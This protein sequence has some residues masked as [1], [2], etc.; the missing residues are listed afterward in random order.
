[1]PFNIVIGRS[2]DDTEKYGTDG[3]VFIGKQYVHMGQVTSLSNN[4]YLDVSRSHVV[5][6]AG[7]RG[8]G[9]CLHEDSI[10]TLG[11]GSHISIKDLFMNARKNGVQVIKEEDEESFSV[12]DHFVI[13]LCGGVVSKRLVSHV[14]RKKIAENLLT[15]KTKKKKIT[16]TK[17]HQ[18]LVSEESN[19]LLLWKRSD[20]L[21]VGNII[22]VSDGKRIEHERI[23]SVESSFYE[24]WVYDITVPETHNFIGNG[25][26]CHNSYSMG[27]IAEGITTLPKDVRQNLSIILLDTMGVYWTMKYPNHQDSSL[28]KEWR[29]EGQGLDVMLFTPSGFYDLYKKKGIPTDKPFAVKPS[30]LHPEDWCLTFG[31]DV[32][33][34]AGVLIARLVQELKKTIKDFSL[35][36]VV[37]AVQDDHRSDEHTKNVVVNHFAQADGWGI[38]SKEGTLLK[39]LV[40][41]GQVTVLDMSP[42]ATMPNGWLIKSIVIGLIS[43]KLFAQRMIARKNEE[44]NQVDQA[45]HY[46]SKETKEKLDDPLVWIS[47]DEAHE[48]LPREGKTVATDALIT[49]LREGRQPGISLLLATQQPGKIHTDVI[50]QSDVVLAHRLTAQV[51]VR[52]LGELTQTYMQEGLSEQLFHLPRAK[53]SGVVFD[54]QNERVFAVKIR[55]R[56]T[57]HGGSA[58]TAIIEKKE[59][60]AEPEKKEKRV[61]SGL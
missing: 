17:E 8:S 3:S 42:Y 29:L 45:M 9:K 16:V 21:T 19:G 37:A 55:P 41:P 6:V 38:F 20:A 35:Q 43:K 34:T 61:F 46:F 59:A 54:D 5:F 4:V 49:I 23:V 31:L 53:G 26:I 33:S 13:S 30:D 18:L 47:V 58:P 14:Y 52:A 25:T 36:E 51:D 32:N 48:F 27:V 44:Y 40:T 2:K 50:T 10:V 39:D 60:F 57:W 1:M 11:D 7:K 22:T 24:G 15:I 12:F 28:L 56:I